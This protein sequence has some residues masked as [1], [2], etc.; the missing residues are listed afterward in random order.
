[1]KKT[2]L[3]YTV[4]DESGFFSNSLEKKFN[5]SE[6]FKKLYER[7][8]MYKLYNYRVGNHEVV[9]FYYFSNESD[10]I[11]TACYQISYL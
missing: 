4:H 1:M 3:N 10:S 11:N 2:K 7:K 5:K 9:T 6:S 8:G